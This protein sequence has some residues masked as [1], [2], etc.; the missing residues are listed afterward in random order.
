[1]VSFH[2]RQQKLAVGSID[3]MVIIYDM[4]TASKWQLFEAHR[5]PIAALSFSP[6]GDMLCSFSPR[7]S[8]K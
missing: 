6:N 7:V 5:F 2:Q 4:R 1:M 3:G 8:E